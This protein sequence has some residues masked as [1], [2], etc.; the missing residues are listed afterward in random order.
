MAT[1]QNIKCVVV[2]DGAVGNLVLSKFFLHYSDFL[3]ILRSKHERPFQEK[4]VFWLFTRQMP[5]RG[6]TCQLCLTIIQPTLGWG[7]NLTYK[8]GLNF[9]HQVD[10]NGTKRTITLGLWDTAGQVMW[11]IWYCSNVSAWQPQSTLNLGN[12]LILVFTF[13]KTM[14]D[15]DHYL[16]Q[17]RWESARWVKL[18]KLYSQ[19]I[20]LACF[21]VMAPESFDNI[22]AKWL[23]EVNTDI[24]RVLVIWQLSGEAP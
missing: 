23:K 1:M 9:V 21:S 8:S 20:F 4:L 10:D 12:I 3:N 7:S 13:R 16:I 17:I 18:T 2:G 15:C 19:D 22:D 5:S 6:S 11:T 24:H 14:T